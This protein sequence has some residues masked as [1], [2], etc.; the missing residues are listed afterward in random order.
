MQILLNVLTF[1]SVFISL[2][3]YLKNRNKN[4]V[5]Y[6]FCYLLAIVLID[7]A[8]G[9][10]LKNGGT[11][12]ILYNCLIFLEFNFLFLFFIQI[13]S[14]KSS[15]QIIKLSLILF[16]FTYVL[17]IFYYGF[18]NIYLIYNAISALLGSALVGCICVIYLREFL[19]SDKVINYKK[20][21]TFWFTIGLLIYYIGG[22]PFTAIIN[23]MKEMPEVIDLFLIMNGLTIFMHICFIIGFIWS[24]KEVK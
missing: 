12:L 18:K 21:V 20:D 19:L 1:L 7:Y 14:R 8:A 3:Y 15:L 10:I 5:F 11:T 16:N 24:W 6:F 22:M 23:Y 17:S 4:G 2:L 13:V 9:I